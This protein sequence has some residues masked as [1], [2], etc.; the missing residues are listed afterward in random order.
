MVDCLICTAKIHEHFAQIFCVVLYRSEHSPSRHFSF[1]THVMDSS[2]SSGHTYVRSKEVHNL[3][4]TIVRWYFDTDDILKTTASLLGKDVNDLTFD[5][6]EALQL[7]RVGS[8][9]V[10]MFQRQGLLQLYDYVFTIE[11]LLYRMKVL[12]RLVEQM[13]RIGSANVMAML[14]KSIPTPKYGRYD[15]VDSTIPETKQGAPARLRLKFRKDADV[16]GDMDL[17]N[18][19]PMR[20]DEFVGRV[21]ANENKANT[22]DDLFA[23]V[24]DC[25]RGLRETWLLQFDLVNGV[26]AVT[27]GLFRVGVS[28]VEL[29]CKPASSVT[30][31]THRVPRGLWVNAFPRDEQIK[32]L[33]RV[34]YISAPC[35]KEGF[36]EVFAQK[37]KREHYKS[38]RDD[39][40]DIKAATASAKEALHNELGGAIPKYRLLPPITR[41]IL[42]I[43]CPIEES[44]LLMESMTPNNA[45]HKCP[46]LA[47]AFRKANGRQFLVSMLQSLIDLYA[48]VRF[49]SDL[50]VQPLGVDDIL[51][52]RFA[53]KAR[54]YNLT[55]PAGMIPEFVDEKDR[56]IELKDAFIRDGDRV[57]LNPKIVR[58]K[59]CRT[60]TQLKDQEL[61]GD[62]LAPSSKLPQNV[63]AT[64]D[65]DGMSQSSAPVPFR[66][67]SAPSTISVSD[68]MSAL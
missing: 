15:N 35:I 6:N 41:S 25:R 56:V 3:I 65:V 30:S 57:Y 68:V 18:A 22:I 29:G 33:E 45:M 50:T 2:N 67:G 38:L 17:N 27:Q 31:A 42:V 47:Y 55:C 61:S 36:L 8:A 24:N 63:W 28:M 44:F 62:L 66:S 46:R 21:L 53:G 58:N 34:T 32:P 26:T 20:Q 11:D 64:R 60:V 59:G 51:D 39:F 52:G 43:D 37:A 13:D 19:L 54:L 5:S 40:N 49:H 48:Q 14:D 7:I 12:R 9:D 4:R 23:I 16:L 1:I 10:D